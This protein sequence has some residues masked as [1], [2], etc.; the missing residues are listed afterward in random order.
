MGNY[1]LLL[2]DRLFAIHASLSAVNRHRNQIMALLRF[3]NV[4]GLSNFWIQSF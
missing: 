2:R 1:P 4:T 3:I